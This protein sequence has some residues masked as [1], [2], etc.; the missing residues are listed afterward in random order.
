MVNVGYWG[1][2]HLQLHR[3]FAYKDVKIKTNAPFAIVFQRAKK[4]II[5]RD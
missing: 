2:K 4:P 3:F 5:G 1:K